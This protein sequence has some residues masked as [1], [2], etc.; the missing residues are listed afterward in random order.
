MLKDII[1]EIRNY[2]GITRKRD[3]YQVTDILRYVSDFGCTVSDFGED[4]AAIVYGDKYLLLAA[5]GIL[6]RLIK[7]DPYAAGKAS[8][9][10]CVN[11]IYTMGGR[12]LAMVNVLGATSF[13]EREK[14]MEGIRKGCQKFRVPMVGGHLHPD[15]QEI[16]LSVA[17]LGEAK[18]LMRSNSARAGDDIIL[19]VD[20]EGRGNACKSVISWDA[21]SGKSSAEVISRL[22]I[23]PCLAEDDLCST[24]K[25]VSNGGIIGTICLM[26]ESSKKGGVIDLDSIPRPSGFDQIDWLKAFLSYGFI[27]CAQGDSTISILSRFREKGIT[28][29]II[30]TVVDQPEVLIKRGDERGILIDFSKE[31][32]TGITKGNLPPYFF[33]LWEL[34]VYRTTLLCLNFQGAEA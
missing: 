4:A 30:G 8:V 32:I 26:L 5:E 1:A 3:I 22:E 24:A 34:S 31:S 10:A 18:K 28:A 33:R 6:P 25:D 2:P 14:V 17:I 21:N 19:A 23:L 15:V 11:D 29:E 13:E 27:L 9:M 7:D 20:L 16:S 12:P